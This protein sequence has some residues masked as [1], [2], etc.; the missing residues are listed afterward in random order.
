MDA[1]T[2]I[3]V[4]CTILDKHLDKVELQSSGKTLSH[5]IPLYPI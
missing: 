1:G 5:V 2:V 3:L 4:D